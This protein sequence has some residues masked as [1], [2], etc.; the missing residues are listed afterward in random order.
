MSQRTVLQRHV[1][2]LTEPL[3]QRAALPDAQLCLTVN[4]SIPSLVPSVRSHVPYL[5]PTLSSF[6]SALSLSICPCIHYLPILPS[7]AHFLI[8]HLGTFAEG[9]CCARHWAVS[10]SDELKLPISVPR[11]FLMSTRRDSSKVDK[12]RNQIR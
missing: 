1:L 11:S 10:R 12:E 9:L 8:H 4:K 5:L 3:S 7:S 6:A 2:T